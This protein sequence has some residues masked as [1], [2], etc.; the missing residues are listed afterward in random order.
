MVA[1]FLSV[2]GVGDRE[3][4][5]WF[6]ESGAGKLGMKTSASYPT[7]PRTTSPSLKPVPLYAQWELLVTT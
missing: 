6:V 2:F 3:S 7:I 4:S 5:V 1:P